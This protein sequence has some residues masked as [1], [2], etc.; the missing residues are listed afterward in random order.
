MSNQTKASLVQFHLPFDSLSTGKEQGKLYQ[1]RDW[2]Y[3]KYWVEKLCRKKIAKL[4]RCGEITIFNWM[5]KYG[6]KGRT[7]SEAQMIAHSRFG[8]KNKGTKFDKDKTWLYRKYII[9]ELSTSQIGTLC[10]V[11]HGTIGKWLRK[12]GIKLR[13]SSRDN[14]KPLYTD[15]NWLYKKYIIEKLTAQKIASLC[16]VTDPTIGNWLKIFSIKVIY[17]NYGSQHIANIKSYYKDRDWLHQQYN[18]E[19]LSCFKISKICGCGQGTINYWI[20]KHD[21]EIRT[22]SETRNK[23]KQLYHNKEWLCQKY[24]KEKLS[25]RETSKICGCDDDTIRYWMKKHDINFRTMSESIKMCSNRLEVNKKI[26]EQAK[27]RWQDP[28]FRKKIEKRNN[29]PEYK[30][31]MKEQVKKRWQDPDFRKKIEKAIAK[32]PTKPEKIFDRIT[33]QEVRYVG[34][35]AY[36]KTLPNG[37]HKNPDFK[38]T[39]QNKVIEIYGDY[40]HRNDDPQELIDLYNQVG[41]QCLIIWENE[42][43]NKKEEVIE[44]VNKFISA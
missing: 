12:F 16:G 21:I 15:K 29:N 22:P 10:K 43:Y 33:S 35:R 13:F 20:K 37:S 14:I 28:D 5:K 8:V 41:L 11:S 30:K 9:E 3:Q 7:I 40:W 42:V 34:N 26:S 38:V 31:M 23:K 6:I 18:I 25:P 2:L 24:W 4:C 19:G 32:R 44:R 36:W 1:N 39:G 17:G 27:E